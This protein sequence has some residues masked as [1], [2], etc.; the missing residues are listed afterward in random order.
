MTRFKVFLLFTLIANIVSA[1]TRQLNGVVTDDLNKGVPSATVKVKGNKAQGLTNADGKFTLS[2]PLGDIVLQVSSIGFA[3]KEVPVA[4]TD[5][6]ISI[7]MAG[8]STALNEV[9]VT[10]LGV[11]R[12]K[13][14][15]TYATQQVSGDELTKAANTN[16]MSAISGKV[17]GVNI[18]ISNSGAGGSTKAVLRGNK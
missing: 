17:A 8:T 10:A 7:T 18:A 5:N 6:D 15:L 3:P 1:Q 13:K 14:S 16:F 12:E 11:K 4:A 9:V 2:V